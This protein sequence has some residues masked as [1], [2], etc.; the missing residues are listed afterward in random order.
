MQEK[1]ETTTRRRWVRT[2][3]IEEEEKNKTEVRASFSFLLLPLLSLSFLIIFR[4]LSSKTTGGQQRRRTMRLKQWH[5]CG[6]GYGAGAAGGECSAGAVGGCPVAGVPL[7][8]VDV[9]V[10][11]VKCC[12]DPLEEVEVL[13]RSAST[14][15][16]SDAAGGGCDAIMVV[17]QV[18]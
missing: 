9:P 5:R 14:G 10:P 3:K 17:G 6:G 2:A 4:R 1:K 11:L 16:G 8:K 13:G 12:G 15:H 18:I 7:E